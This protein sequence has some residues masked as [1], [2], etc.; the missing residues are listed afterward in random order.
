MIGALTPIMQTRTKI[1]GFGEKL[2]IRANQGLMKEYGGY[3][4]DKRP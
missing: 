2:T 3:G 1:V 4:N